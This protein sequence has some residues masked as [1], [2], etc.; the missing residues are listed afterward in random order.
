[1]QSSGA[2]TARSP[3]AAGRAGHLHPCGKPVAATLQQPQRPEPLTSS[4]GLSARSLQAA[5]GQ[6]GATAALASPHEAAEHGMAAAAVTVEQPASSQQEGLGGV[7]GLEPLAS[8][9]DQGL[10]APRYTPEPAS[11]R[12]TTKRTSRHAADHCLRKG[13]PHHHV[14][15]LH[16]AAGRAQ[17]LQVGSCAPPAGCRGSARRR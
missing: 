3:Q 8:S 6:H 7:A 1:M 10:T 14:T 17:R 12:L 2:A 13:W 15:Q 16:Q 4:G 5:T 9:G 11:R